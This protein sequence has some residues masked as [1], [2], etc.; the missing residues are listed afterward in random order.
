MNDLAFMEA[1]RNYLGLGWQEGGRPPAD[2]RETMPNAGID[3]IG[4]IACACRDIGHTEAFEALSAAKRNYHVMKPVLTRFARRD[5]RKPG[6]IL[7]H[8]NAS[9]L[10]LHVAVA[11]SDKRMI[12]IENQFTKVVEARDNFPVR[13]VW[14]IAWP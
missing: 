2:W 11:T 4:I 13:Q 8:W 1:A 10:V 7:L 14:S 3:C 12:H 5:A 6:S 9:S